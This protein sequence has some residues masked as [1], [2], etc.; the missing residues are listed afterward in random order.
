MQILMRGPTPAA[1]QCSPPTHQLSQVE[2]RNSSKN[3]NQASGNLGKLTPLPPKGP[4]NCARRGK[5]QTPPFYT[6]FPPALQASPPRKG[7]G[8]WGRGTRRVRAGCTAHESS[9]PGPRGDD[10]FTVPEPTATRFG[11]TGT[12]AHAASLILP[13]EFFSFNS[14]SWRLSTTA[15]PGWL[16]LCLFY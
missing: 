10:S 4:P 7:R 5:K 3:G 2:S 16:C 6:L 15:F 8:P 1:N 14:I 13:L 12:A 11:R 9:A